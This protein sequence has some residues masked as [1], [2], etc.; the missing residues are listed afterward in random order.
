MSRVGTGPKDANDVTRGDRPR[1]SAREEA[2]R[3]C[4]D[5]VGKVTARECDGERL[6]TM[7]E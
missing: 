6:L 7:G 1:G 5:N 4:D 2:L 3:N